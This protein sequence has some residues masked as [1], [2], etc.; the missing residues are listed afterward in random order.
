M[1]GLIEELKNEHQFLQEKLQDIKQ[2]GLT[3]EEGKSELFEIK[4]ALLQHLKKED[5]QLYPALQ[6]HAENNPQFKE[7][8]DWYVD[9][10]KTISEKAMSFF[11]KY[12]QG[13]TDNTEFTKDLGELVG[14]LKSRINKE[15]MV[16]F[17][18]Y[19]EIQQ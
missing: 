2:K 1:A 6:K 13:A 12:E 3:S 10:M 18:K 9:E 11:Q 14:L 7:T 4:E 17:K 5:E 16:L 15:E 19:E 8:L